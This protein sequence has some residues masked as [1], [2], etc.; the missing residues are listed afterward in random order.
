M[1]KK[2][3]QNP[4]GPERFCNPSWLWKVFI[5][6]KKGFVPKGAL[7]KSVVEEWMVLTCK[8]LI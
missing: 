6:F 2:L 4:K 7:F 1:S 8:S 3:V 5:F